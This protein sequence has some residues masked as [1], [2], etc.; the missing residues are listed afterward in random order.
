MRRR[1]KGEKGRGTNDVDE[2]GD[3]RKK[4][5][6]VERVGEVLLRV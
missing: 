1:K 6:L 4:V 2:A 3:E 5:S